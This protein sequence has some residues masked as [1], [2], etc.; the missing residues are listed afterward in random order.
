MAQYLGLISNTTAI[1]PTDIWKLADT[2]IKPLVANQYSVGF[3]K[4]FGQ[5]AF[6]TSLEVYYK[7]FNNVTEYKD[8]ADLILNESI[9]T[10]LLKGRARAYGAEL[11]VKK[12]SGKIT[13]W[14]SYTYSRSLRRVIGLYEEETINAGAWYPSNF[15]KPHD[16][17]AVVEFKTGPL[18][19]FASIF[20]YSQGRPVSYPVA[21]FNYLDQN[22]AYYDIRNGNR[23]PSYHR[24]D[25]SMT[26]SIGS[27]TKLLNW[28]LDHLDLQCLWPPQCIFC[29]L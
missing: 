9:E 20:T 2:H 11:L 24:L 6:E 28:R 7:Q 4:N 13:G 8:G 3:F 17:T 19:K 15:D 12:N 14:V 16:L 5:G 26:F 22:I 1:A 25:L 27:H 10:E 23:V 21:K 29:I 18:M